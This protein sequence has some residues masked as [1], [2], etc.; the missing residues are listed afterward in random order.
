MDKGAGI[1]L[2]RK[3]G[4]QVRRGEPLYRIHAESETGLAFARDLATDDT[5]YRI[6]S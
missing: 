6:L 1:D 3:V 4:D 5:G 2:L